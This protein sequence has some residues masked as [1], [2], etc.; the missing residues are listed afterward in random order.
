MGRHV[1]LAKVRRQGARAFGIAA[2]PALFGTILKVGVG[3]APVLTQGLIQQDGHGFR[4]NFR[5]A[6]DLQIVAKHGA[7]QLTVDE[8][9]D[10]AATRQGRG[11]VFHIFDGR[12]PF[13]AVGMLVLVKALVEPKIDRHRVGLVGPCG[14]GV[15]RVGTPVVEV[16]RPAVLQNGFVPCHVGEFPERRS[17]RGFTRCHLERGGQQRVGKDVFHKH[18]FEKVDFGCPPSPIGLQAVAGVVVASIDFLRIASLV[19]ADIG[20]KGPHVIRGVQV[21][22]AGQVSHHPH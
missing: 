1:L 8:P 15:V 16:E 19:V 20:A 3:K 14:V 6:D 18:D 12:F 10:V 21:G 7:N 17:V 2:T 13:D 4:R 5:F 9:F 22:G 11:R